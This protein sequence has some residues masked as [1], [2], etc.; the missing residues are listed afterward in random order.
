MGFDDGSAALRLTAMATL[1]FLVAGPAVAAPDARAGAAISV[2][3]GACHG[4]DGISADTS[5]PNLAGQHYV[6]LLNQLEAYKGKT[7]DNPIM[8][9]MVVPL[10]QEQMEDIAAYYA[11]IPIKV[12]PAA[13]NK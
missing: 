3:C 7:R 12:E 10:S 5:I 8:S 6:Y 1:A 2:Q 4:N 13:A 9:Q 11:S